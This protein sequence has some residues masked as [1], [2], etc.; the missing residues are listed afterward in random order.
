VSLEPAEVSLLKLLTAQVAELLDD[1]PA[2][3]PTNDG[4]EL[5]DL[6]DASMKPVDAPD[7]PVLRRLLPDAYRDDAGAAVEFRR[8]TE[9]D[10]RATKLDALSRITTDLSVPAVTHRT[11]SVRLDLDEDA[12]AAWLPALTDIRLALGTRIDVTEDMDDERTRLPVDSARYA[13]IATYDWLSWLQDAMV[14]AVS[15]D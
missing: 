2:R 13:E 9:S 6:L 4:D 12:A 14:R 8:L 5:Q 7:D 10:L 11:G 1:A 15:G 3:H